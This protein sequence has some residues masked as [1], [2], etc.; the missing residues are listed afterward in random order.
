MTLQHAFLEQA[1]SCFALGSPYM[2][3]VMT[4]LAQHWPE[5]TELARCFANWSGDIGPS[6]ASLPLRLAGGLHALVLQGMDAELAAVYPPHVVDDVVLRDAVVAAIRRHDVFLCCWAENAPQTNEVRRSAVLIAAAHWLDARYGLPIR[7]SELGASAGLNLVFDKF[8]MQIG[9]QRWGPA[10]STVRL[11]PEWRGPLPPHASPRIVERRGVDLNPLHVG[12]ADDELRLMSYIWADQTDRMT[13]TQAAMK[14]QNQP[15]EKGDAIAWLKTR[16]A[17]PTAG[18]LHLIYHTIAWQYFPA[19]R[20]ATGR[21]MIEAAGV[22]ATENAPLAWF[23]MEADDNSN[24][25]ALTLRL[26]PG[27]VRVS[28]ARAGFHGQWVEWAGDWSD[29]KPRF[30]RAIEPRSRHQQ[31][32]TS[33]S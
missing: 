14:L 21:A 17:L 11:A 23:G 12:S 7:L 30:A 16:L 18:Q 29:F 3:R 26:W 8:N 25:A 15:V 10:D 33:R 27:D 19:E 6:G 4:L 28:L 22:A 9:D 20:Q 31:G 5:D 13:R 1:K 2:G 24:G 32:K